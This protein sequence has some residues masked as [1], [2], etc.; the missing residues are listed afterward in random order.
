MD[1]D[2]VVMVDGQ[3]TVL[4]KSGHRDDQILRTLL[5]TQPHLVLRSA[6]DDRALRLLLVSRRATAEAEPDDVRL[7]RVYVDSQG[8]PLLVGVQV[9]PDSPADGEALLGLLDRVSLELPRWRDGRLRQQV[10]LTHGYRDEAELLTSTLE[11]RGGAGAFWARVESNLARDHVRIVLVADELTDGLTRAVDFLDAQLRDVE[12]RAVEVSLFGS[13]EMSA[14]VA[15]RA[16]GSAAQPTARPPAQRPELPA[17]PQR[18]AL[19]DQTGAT[20]HG[21]HD[22]DRRVGAPSGGRHRLPVESG[23]QTDSRR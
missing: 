4:H 16:R 9:A 8:V 2:V 10:L 5:D 14:V 22:T 20:V 17:L 19:D 3:V 6:H 1:D 15:R 13:G 23:N 18:T 7:E 21:L 12:I 11:W